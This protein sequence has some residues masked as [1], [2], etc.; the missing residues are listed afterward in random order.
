MDINNELLSGMLNIPN[1]PNKDDGNGVSAMYDLSTDSYLTDLI[2]QK[3]NAI[4]GLEKQAVAQSAKI[5]KEVQ[6][7][8]VMH[9]SIVAEKA[10]LTALTANRNEH[11]KFYV[12]FATI[13]NAIDNGRIK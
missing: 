2:R 11:G 13:P 12:N 8:N 7:L 6:T 3:E 10:S 4:Q 1:I 9:I 5:D